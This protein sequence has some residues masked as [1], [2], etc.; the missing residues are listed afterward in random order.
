MSITKEG[1]FKYQALNE[2]QRKNLM[3][4]E[5]IRK[6]GPVSKTVLSKQLGY[7][8]VTLSNHIEEYMKKRLVY[9]TGIDVSSGGRRPVLLELN[10]NEIFLIGID[11][12]KEILTG[13]LTDFMLNIISEAKIAR[14]QI[15][16]EEIEKG[17][18]T[19][20][21]ELIKG[22]KADASKVKFIA[23]G[24]YG[25]IWEKNGAIK[26]LD[27]DKG[28][29]RATIYFTELKHALEKEFNIPTFFGADSSFAAF[30]EKARNPG[31]EVDN[32][33][34]VFQDVGKGVVIK[35][36]IYCSTDLGSADLEGITGALND[37]EKNKLREESAYLKPWNSQMNLRNEAIRVI[38]DGVGTKIVELLNGNLDG[39]NDDVII[40]AAKDDDE[41][42]TELIEGVGINLGVRIAYLINLFSPQVVIVGGGI[43][44]AGETLFSQIE[45]TIEKLSLEKAGHT[46]KIL[47]SSLGNRAV[48]L[49]AASVALREIFLEA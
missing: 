35:G 29:S 10:K 8:I 46:T 5:T 40:K 42:A 21:K 26:G 7:N 18:I 37:E 36:E 22:A 1:L 45:K 24:T 16:Q 15:E 31:A 49:G 30:G 11:F 32:M 9:E 14:P 28:R 48:S 20:V 2:R 23:I 6:K 47:P 43:E 19:I 44:R 39:I 38:K 4:L 17:M 3:I 12:N 33:L 27:D 13:V 25:T 41:I 34:Y